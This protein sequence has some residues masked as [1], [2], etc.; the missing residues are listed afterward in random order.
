MKTE[1]LVKQALKAELHYP[2]APKPEIKCDECGV[3]GFEL[4]EGDVFGQ[5][6]RLCD[7]CFNRNRKALIPPRDEKNHPPTPYENLFGHW[8]DP[9]IDLESRVRAA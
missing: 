4:R 1:E 3:K 8:L 9:D 7:A 2:E 6:F 5:T